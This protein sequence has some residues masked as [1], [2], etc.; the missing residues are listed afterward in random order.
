MC[1][2]EKVTPPL[3]SVSMR[4]VKPVPRSDGC[5]SSATISSMFG[6]RL[7]AADLPSDCHRAVCRLNGGV[8]LRA[9]A[10]DGQVLPA[11]S[12]CSDGEKVRGGESSELA[13]TAGGR[14]PSCGDGDRVATWPAGGTGAAAE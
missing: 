12:A 2:L 13:A 7:A 1:A 14:A 9:G 3:P 6:P 8:L 4:G 11:E 10:L 5:R